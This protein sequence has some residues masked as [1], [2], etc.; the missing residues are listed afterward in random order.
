MDPSPPKSNYTQ[1]SPEKVVST[2]TQLRARIAERFPE[3]G[4]LQVCLELEDL[5]QR[6]RLR[7]EW[8]GR[9]IWSLRILR[10]LLIILI[11]LGLLVLFIG[12]GKDGVNE[13][14][15]FVDWIQ[16]L[17]AG[18]NDI[19]LISLAVFFVW[20]LEAR[21]KRRR[22]MKALHEL[23]SIAH[24]IDMHQ[25]TKDPDRILRKWIDTRSSPKMEMSSFNL[26]R[27]L[28]Y[29]SEMLS[30]VSKVAALHLQSLEDGTVIAAV[31]EIEELTTG[32][33]RKIWQKIDI[34]RSV[35]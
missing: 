15:G 23:R 27:Y 3:S 7:I 34:L 20:N 2:V 9:P 29:C 18:I 21:V 24:V 11:V 14:L 30:L 13:N 16:T 5:C 1:L 33:S 31:N 32:L 17:E 8:I 6:S 19:V 25:L 12:L 22:A 10:Y 28:D 35:E 4:L 26:R